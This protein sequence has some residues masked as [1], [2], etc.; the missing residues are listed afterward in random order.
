MAE[1]DGANCRLLGL[2]AFYVVKAVQFAS[3]LGTRNERLS[4][5]STQFS[6][7]R[8]DAVIIGVSES[9]VKAA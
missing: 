2:I 9:D 7:Y 6:S 8:D 1:L 3:S 5:N 4:Q